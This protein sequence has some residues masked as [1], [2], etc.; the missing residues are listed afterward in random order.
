M[1]YLCSACV[2][3]ICGLTRRCLVA[4]PRH[5]KQQRCHS[6][7]KKVWFRNSRNKSKHPSIGAITVKQ[8]PAPGLGPDSTHL[9][10]CSHD[11]RLPYRV[12]YVALAFCSH[13]KTL[14]LPTAIKARHPNWNLAALSTN[15]NASTCVPAHLNLLVWDVSVNVA[16]RTRELMKPEMSRHPSQTEQGTLGWWC[17]KAT[18]PML[19][20]CHLAAWDWTWQAEHMPQPSLL[21]KQW[22]PW[23][24]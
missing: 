6:Q 3:H 5:L 23:Q 12:N 7:T 20:F 1:W 9:E 17:S 13:P 8:D 18:S 11:L 4:Q 19:A 15:Y 2:V 14:Y 24:Y 10:S 16:A 22:E 21:L